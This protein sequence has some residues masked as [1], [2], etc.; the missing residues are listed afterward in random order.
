VLD[1]VGSHVMSHK[2]LKK[3]YDSRI[4]AIKMA[5]HTSADLQPLNKTVSTCELEVRL[6]QKWLFLHFRG[7][8]DFDRFQRQT[9]PEMP[10]EGT[11]RW[12]SRRKVG[13]YSQLDI[14]CTSR[15]DTRCACTANMPDKRR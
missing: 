2:A 15:R 14:S 5:S 13:I 12:K 8:F 3:F 7:A 9:L 11:I 4:I 10:R 1:A 6:T